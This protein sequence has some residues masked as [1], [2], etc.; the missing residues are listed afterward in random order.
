[1]ACAYLSMKGQ[2]TD[3]T[4]P[5][6]RLI[7]KQDKDGEALRCLKGQTNVDSDALLKTIS[8]QD[9]N[10]EKKA[11]AKGML[12]GIKMAI[13]EQ[14]NWNIGGPA[15]FGEDDRQTMFKYK[16]PKIKH[17]SLDESFD[18]DLLEAIYENHDKQDDGWNDV[19]SYISDDEGGPESGRISPCT[20]ARWAEGATRWDQP[21]DK[22]KSVWEDRKDYEIPADRQRPPSPNTY[23]P[24]ERKYRDYE[25][26]ADENDGSHLTGACSEYAK[27]EPSLLWSPPPSRPAMN[28]ELPHD[29][30][31]RQFDR[32]DPELAKVLR[33]GAMST[34]N[35]FGLGPAESNEDL[36]KYSQAEVDG[37]IEK[38]WGLEA[39]FK[40]IAEKQ[41]D[42]FSLNRNEE[43]VNASNER[44]RAMIHRLKHENRKL[45][46]CIA[47]QDN[48][49][50]RRVLQQVDKH[51]RA[52]DW[53]AKAKF[54][55][56]K[57]RWRENEALREELEPLKDM[58]R[59]LLEKFGKQTAEEVFETFPDVWKPLEIRKNRRNMS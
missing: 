38:Y 42:L 41:R 6:L 17:L 54:A 18:P 44:H 39:V 9:N 52:L 15:A 36:G 55:E 34:A 25:S 8:K 48:I 35:S 47:L 37:T 49:R 51:V 11:G 26:Q 53:E 2:G 12:T 27:T 19:S 29:F 57:A 22:H 32:M 45:S 40:I 1:M 33:E 56:V 10:G 46:D 3:G 58:H 30:W 16:R 28:A 7:A 31:N 13:K 4:D 50:E 59:K 21:G 23:E 14:F 20:F 43:A 5:L 24:R